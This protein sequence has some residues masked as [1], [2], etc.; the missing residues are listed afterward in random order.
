MPT[1][2]TP[3]IYP[4]EV[5]PEPPP[6]FYTGVPAFLG[7]ALQGPFSAP[8]PLSF[9]AQFAETFGGYLEHG[10]LAYAVRGFFENGGRLCYVLRLDADKFEAEK[11]EAALR[12][13]LKTIAP[14]GTIDLVC[15]PDIMLEPADA[16]ALQQMVVDHCEESGDRLAILDALNPHGKTTPD[17]IRKV[18][19]QRRQL[20]GA[21]AALYFPWIRI[22]DGPGSKISFM[23]PCGHV[24]GVYART[25]ERAGVHKAP[26]N[27]DLAGVLDLAFH[28]TDPQQGPLNDAGV[29]CLRAFPGRGIRVWGARTLSQD[30]A[31]RYVNVRRLFLTAGRWIERATAGVPF[32]PNDFR[33][34]VRV[35]RELGAYFND[36]FRR[37]ALKGRTQDEAFYVK[38]N[39]ET[40]PLE[41]R[42]AGMVVTEVGL[43]PAIPNE[44]VV[45]RLI[46]GAGGVTISGPGRPA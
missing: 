43:A 15:V 28:L 1:Y 31:W 25:D 22:P 5:Y 23:P 13:G 4:E 2:Q 14:M 18:K 16:P 46:H 37:G 45:V 12:E 34:W 44:F 33:L 42:E 17:A 40:N 38:C 24:A 29:N 30:P 39:A 32:E 26:A 41:V 9:W 20:R 7:L 8:E 3:G 6:T 21:N 11:F 10:Y 19:E 27:E 35:E 36:L